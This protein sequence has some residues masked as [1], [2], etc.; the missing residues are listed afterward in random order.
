MSTPH[1]AQSKPR[2]SAARTAQKPKQTQPEEPAE[3]KS[4]VTHDAAFIEPLESEERHARHSRIAE[5]AYYLAERRSFDPGHELDDWLEAEREIERAQ[6][7]GESPHL[8]GD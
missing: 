1:T 7:T 8:C 4:I 2:R 3:V 6:E 5:A